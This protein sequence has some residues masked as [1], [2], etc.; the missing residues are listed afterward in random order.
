MQLKDHAVVLVWKSIVQVE[1]PHNE[2]LADKPVGSHSVRDKLQIH[3]FF[4]S[5][6]YTSYQ[7]IEYKKN[8]H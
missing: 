6:H 3:H 4:E 8:T 7:K 1:R 5:C 2:A